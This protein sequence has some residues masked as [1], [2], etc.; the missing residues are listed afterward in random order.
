MSTERWR[1]GKDGDAPEQ[2]AGAL[3]RSVRPHPPSAELEARVQAVLR[4]DEVPSRTGRPIPALAA[5]VV[6]LLL[7]GGAAAATM[8]YRSRTEPEKPEPRPPVVKRIEPPPPP[9]V[10]VAPP[11]AVE[12]P[13]PKPPAPRSDPSRLALESKRIKAAVDALRAGDPSTALLE[14]AAYEQA[15]PKGILHREA[16][17]AKVSALAALHRE[18]E[19]LA[20]LDALEIDA[21]P[22]SLELT[23][24]RGELRARAGR[25][26]DAAADFQAALGGDLE[27]KLRARAEKGLLRCR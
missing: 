14:I 9:I 26:E 11:P 12:A 19:A 23:V 22:R 5:V 18:S 2:R 7:A 4:G 25:C 8:I 16:L 21:H 24:L 3:F 15:H 6:F 13:V 27:E 17:L 1:D 10:Q 20:I